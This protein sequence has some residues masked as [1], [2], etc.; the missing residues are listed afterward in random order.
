MD[1]ATLT[2][3]VHAVLRSRISPSSLFE[4]LVSIDDLLD[5]CGSVSLLFSLEPVLLHLRGP[6][7][8]VGDIHGNIDDLLRIFG[9]CGY[10]PHQ[11][12]LFLGDYVDRGLFSIEVLTLLFALKCKFPD[13]IFLLRGNHET[14]SI[15]TVY[16]LMG[17][18]KQRFGPVLF[19]EFH[20]V[21]ENLPIAAVVER[22]LFCVHGGLSPELR[23][24]GE[25]QD[26]EKP[27]GVP[28]G[29]AADLLW[30]DPSASVEWFEPNPRGIGQLFGEKAAKGFLEGNRLQM[31][32]RSH[33]ACSD[34]MEWPFGD[35]HRAVLTV[36]ST[37]DYCGS[38]N[39]GVVIRVS[40]DLMLEKVG[41]LALSEEER[42]KKRVILPDWLLIDDTLQSPIDTDHESQPEEALWE[43]TRVTVQV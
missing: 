9:E 41:L 33:E 13:E 34:G 22:A 26:M 29:I 18:C 4:D 19:S 39:A 21:F 27:G 43:T 17:E 3:L 12:Y 24:I 40:K 32:V 7:V 25:F 11:R 5:L 15:S 37:T 2:S 8:L 28:V 10:P 38:G 30:S 20:Y 42:K 36:F 31:V 23:K 35:R 14:R 1:S 6:I 16:G